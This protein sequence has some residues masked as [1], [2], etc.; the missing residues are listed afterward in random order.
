MAFVGIVWFDVGAAGTVAVHRD[1]RHVG[2]LITLWVATALVYPFVRRKVAWFVDWVILRRPDYR[3]L[4]TAVTREIQ[5]AETVQAVLSGACA[6]LG[7]ALSSTG[8]TWREWRRPFAEEPLVRAGQDAVDATRAHAPA[9]RH[10]GRRTLQLAGS[11][12][13]VPT[14]EPPRFA[15]AI[16]RLTGGRRLLSDDLA[17]LEAIAITVARRVDA[18]RMTD[19]RY[20]REIREQEIGKLATEAELRALRAQVNPH[21]LFNALTT[22]GYLIQT[23]PPRALQTLLRL[24]VPAARRASLRRRIHDPGREIELVEAYLDIERA[25]FEER[26]RVRI[27]VPSRLRT[28]RS[29]RG[30][31]AA[32]RKRRQ[33]WYRATQ[34]RRRRDHSA[35]GWTRTAITS[36][37]AAAGRRGHRRRHISRSTRAGRSRR[38]RSRNV[39]RRLG[40]SLRCGGITRRSERRAKA[41]PWKSGCRRPR[42]SPIPRRTGRACE[43]KLRVVVADDERPARS[44]LLALLRS[45]DDVVVVGEAASGKAAVA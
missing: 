29:R 45:F 41:R 42:Q 18:V 10:D 8:V 27:D 15:I 35:P 5:A 44:F 25:R 14:T 40:L 11:V 12:V 13:I 4:R 43:R 30:A 19:E 17:T 33:A 36:R 39:E 9:S 7:P 20:E 6:L 38:R 3:S 28:A 24:T 21:F 37:A 34:R 31:A 1:P 16:S 2:L 26:L 32:G 22:I 23:A